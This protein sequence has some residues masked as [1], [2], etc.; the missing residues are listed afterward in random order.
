MNNEATSSAPTQNIAEFPCASTV[1]LL[2]TLSMCKPAV[3]AHDRPEALE[4]LLAWVRIYS[5]AAHS[6]D[7]R[8]AA[9]AALSASGAAFDCGLVPKTMQE[10]GD[11]A[12]LQVHE[13]HT[14]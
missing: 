10:Y 12:G 13:R 14:T 11:A 1:S 6:E 9:A 5:S 7:M 4:L 3:E 2:L 8:L